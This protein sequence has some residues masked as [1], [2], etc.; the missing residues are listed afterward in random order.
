MQELSFMDNKTFDK[1][2]TIIIDILQEIYLKGG[3]AYV[4]ITK[5]YDD[6]I[7]YY[8]NLGIEIL[9]NCYLPDISAVMLEL[10][11]NEVENNYNIST[12]Q[13]N[14]LILLKHLFPKIQ[15][16]NI[17]YILDFQSMFCSNNVVSNNYNKISKYL[18]EQNDVN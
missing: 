18:N 17:E 8:R 1:A 6:A 12:G 9:Q 2:V 7:C 16:M 3:L 14:I 15:T 4:E 13:K 10:A 11:I 5:E